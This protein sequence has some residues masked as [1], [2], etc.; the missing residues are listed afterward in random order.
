MPFTLRELRCLIAVAEEGR[1][2]SAAARLRSTQP[3]VSQALDRLEMRL[4]AP[5]LVRHARG[6][7]LTPAGRAL[8]EKAGAV[9]A[10]AEEAVAA[11]GP[12]ARGE[13]RLLLGVAQGTQPLARPLRRE[14]AARRPEIELAVVELGPAERLSRLRAGRI[15]AELAYPPPHEEGLRARAMLHSPCYAVLS[16]RHRLAA[17]PSLRLED[18][19]GELM[20]CPAEEAAGQLAAR[21][22]MT[23]CPGKGSATQRDGTPALDELWPLICAG[24]AAALLPRFMLGSVVGDGVRAVPLEGVAPLEVAMVCRADD[25][26][27][28]VAALLEL[29]AGAREDGRV[30]A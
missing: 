21:G 20:P 17:A 9:V 15:D 3:A 22:W 4:G 14:I 13:Q 26:R 11:V 16:E 12:W 10:A 6:V 23:T 24:R 1:M 29:A 27:E 8:Y 7:T 2:T 30:A 28:A 18:V 19:A 25:E 5:L